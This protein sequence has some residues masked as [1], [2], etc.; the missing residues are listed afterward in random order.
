M[1][2]MKNVLFTGA[3]P[4][5]I[6]IGSAGFLV[7][8]LK[9]EKK[10]S[11]V[12]FSNCEEQEGN[13]GITKEFFK[14]M[15]TL[16]VNGEVKLL[17]FQNTKL[18]L[19][20]EK[21]RRVLERMKKTLK[22]ELIVTHSVGNLHQDHKIVSEECL[23]VFRYSTIIAYEDPKSTVNFQPNLFVSLSEEEFNKKIEAIKCYKTQLRRKY[24]S[25]EIFATFCRMR[26][27]QAG[28]KYAEGFEIV[29]MIL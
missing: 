6:E 21:I 20:R 8:L 17:N 29:R 13:K 12:V 23:R 11:C 22:P 2:K 28:V 15:K 14:S 10:V 7:K 16:G 19:S 26:G 3:H 25:P 27:V 1:F 24:Y 9:N 5:D 4:D 18:Y